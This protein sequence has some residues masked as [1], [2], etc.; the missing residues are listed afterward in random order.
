MRTLRNK[1]TGQIIQ[2]DDSEL[3]KYGLAPTMA[4]PASAAPTRSSGLANLLPLLGSLAGG[5]L[6]SPLP[7]GLIWGSAL[8][9]GGGE[10]LRQ[11]LGG[12]EADVG[13]VLGQGV[14][15]GA[16]GA[17]G[18]GLGKLLG[19]GAKAAGGMG[20]GAKIATK[21]YTTEAIQRL[22]GKNIAGRAAEIGETATTLKGVT[23]PSKLADLG[24]KRE[25]LNT[26]LGNITQKQ[27]ATKAI[28]GKVL[29]S[30]VKNQAAASAIDLGSG[31]GKS[32]IKFWA[33]QIK[34]VSSVKEL[35]IL[36]QTILNQISKVG[37]KSQQ[38]RILE[39]I[40]APLT[41]QLNTAADTGEIFQALSRLNAAEPIIQGQ[42]GAS[43]KIFGFETQIPQRLQEGLQTGVGGAVGKVGSAATLG[44]R[45]PLTQTAGQLGARAFAPR[46]ATQ[47]YTPEATDMGGVQD[48]NAQPKQ[49]G[50]LSGLTKEKVALAY[51]TLPK[52]QAD[53]IAEAFKVLNPKE[54]AGASDEFIKKADNAI[55]SLNNMSVR[56][57]GPIQGGIYNLQLSKFGGSGLPREAIELGQRYTALKL[58][59]L[60][61]YQG[62][63]ISDKDFDLAKLYIPNISDTDTTARIKVD[64]LKELITSLNLPEEGEWTG[65]S[66]F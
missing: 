24:L 4:M 49:E 12:E 47:Q 26:L 48:Y 45:V 37:I 63:R 44:G 2:V 25:S 5:A 59:I 23:A 54:T 42:A 6:A 27:M 60:R 22:T 53:A 34:K 36:N 41:E 33:P 18:L 17:L 7:G 11:L 55:N 20:T 10:A 14:V 13:R 57:Y 43:S 58:A 3:P 1:R 29:L 30:T 9:S 19:T 8:G 51:L 40:R 61:A 46:G 50:A 56:G 39:A 28:D 38:G 15:G 35:S 16:G 62:A 64:V 31:A 65:T 21:P 32:A 52:K 66:S